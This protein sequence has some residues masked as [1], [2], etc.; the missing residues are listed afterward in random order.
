MGLLEGLAGEDVPCLGLLAS[1]LGWVLLAPSELD[2]HGDAG[3][4]ACTG[5]TDSQVSSAVVARGVT[6][7]FPS[8]LLR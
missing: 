8:A 1:L 6:T 5:L 3:R 2:A 7:A 4:V